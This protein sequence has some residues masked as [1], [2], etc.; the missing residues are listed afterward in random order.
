MKQVNRLLERQI[1]RNF[2]SMEQVPDEM[3]DLLMAVSDSYDHYER[4][5]TLIERAMEINSIELRQSYE[6]LTIQAHLKRSNQELQQFVNT[7]SHDLKAPLR[8]IGS[9]STLL[10]RRLGQNIDQ[11]AKEYLD[12][13]I[14]G[15]QRMHD[16]INDLLEHARL[17]NQSKRE[18]VVDLNKILLIVQKNLLHNI[19]ESGAQIYIKPL[20]TIKGYSSQLVR[21]F[22]NLLGNAIKFR[23]DQTP[24]IKVQAVN[25]DEGCLFSVT[26]NGIGIENEFQDKVFDLFKRLKTQDEYEGSGLGLSICKKI[27]TNHHGK[28]WLESEPGKGTTFFFSLPTDALMTDLEKLPVLDCTK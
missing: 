6:K 4:D 24:V 20:P 1:K 11:T 19:R 8:S 14:A 7:A 5:R 13:I 16:L 3:W 27:I 10:K 12:F 26:D 2:G 25:S 23:G 21:L 17:E 22:Q 28:I 9:F 18:E 15:V